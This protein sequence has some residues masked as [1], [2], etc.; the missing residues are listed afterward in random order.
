MPH[1]AE[2]ADATD[3]RQGLPST[4]AAQFQ[5][6]RHLIVEMDGE[7]VDGH[8]TGAII[9]RASAHCRPLGSLDR[10]LSSGSVFGGTGCPSRC[11]RPGPHQLSGSGQYPLACH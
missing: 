5:G 6:A 3:D 2:G 11:D 1:E 8:G 7:T 4:Q 9:L 10:P